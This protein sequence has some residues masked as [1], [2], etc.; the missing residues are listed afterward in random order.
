MGSQ[1]PKALC[2][3]LKLISL[4]KC[5]FCCALAQLPS[6]CVKNTQ[7]PWLKVGTYWR[8]QDTDLWNLVARPDTDQD[9]DL[10]NLVARSRHRSLEPSGETK[11]LSLEPSG[12][13]QD[14]DLWNLLARPRHRFL[15]PS[16]ETK[17][18]SGTKWRNQD[19]DLWN[20]VAR[21]RH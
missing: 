12:K 16:G 11:T 7:P 2:R 4:H 21:P 20:I 15:E 14:T 18:I 13:T 17:T 8:D 19:T 1:G 10:S 3:Q 5:R 9:T 6:S